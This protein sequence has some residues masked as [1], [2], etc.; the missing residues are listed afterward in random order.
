MSGGGGSGG[1]SAFIVET[2][3]DAQLGLELMVPLLFLF[4]MVKGQLQEK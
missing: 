4:R 3:M 2:G 1:G